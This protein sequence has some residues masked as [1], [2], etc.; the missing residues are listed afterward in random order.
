MLGR[1]VNNELERLWK[2]AVMTQSRDSP[3]ICLE[4]LRKA[5]TELSH[6]NQFPERDSNMASTEFKSN[7]L[8]LDQS[9]QC[10]FFLIFVCNS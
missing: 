8:P 3:I 9:V 10:V 7:M 1:L 5:P 4:E 6:D 2:E